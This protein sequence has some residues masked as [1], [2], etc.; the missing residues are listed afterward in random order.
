MK[1]ISGL[2]D[3]TEAALSGVEGIQSVELLEM[4]LI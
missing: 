3:Q 4:S 2:S 1:D